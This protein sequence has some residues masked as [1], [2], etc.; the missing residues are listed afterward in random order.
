V[1]FD[2]I[3]PFEALA[4]L[5]AEPDVVAPLAPMFAG[6]LNVEL[7]DALDVPLVPAEADSAEPAAL[8]APLLVLPLVAEAFKVL[9]PALVA[10]AFRAALAVEELVAEFALVE[11]LAADWVL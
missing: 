4:A 5:F 2:A 7:L 9:E 10:L 11:L 1:E 3:A 8:A 6:L